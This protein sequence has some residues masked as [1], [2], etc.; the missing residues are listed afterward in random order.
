[1]RAKILHFSEICKK[2]CKIIV[3][4]NKNSQISHNSHANFC[5]ALFALSALSPSIVQIVQKVQSKFL[6][7]S[8]VRSVSFNKNLHGDIDDIGD[9]ANFATFANA[10]FL[11]GNNFWLFVMGK[12]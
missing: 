2:I 8:F 12:A 9:I 3:P 7:V 4:Q 6:H 1:L 11:F 10:F 5:I